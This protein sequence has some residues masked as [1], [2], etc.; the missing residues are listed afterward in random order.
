MSL[1]LFFTRYRSTITGA[2][3]ILA[4]S[5]LASRLLGLFRD[6]LLAGRFGTGKLLDAYQVSFLLPDL[7]YNLFIIG[8]L[9]A[10]LIPVF[11]EIY[12][13]NK[14]EAWDLISR[15]LNLLG[16]FIFGI[17]LVCFIFTPQIVHLLG[18]LAQ[19]SDTAYAEENL[20]LI[21]KLTRLML[22]SPLL[23]GL[24]SLTTGIL[25]SLKHFLPSALSPV[26]YNLGIILGILV[27]APFW[28]IYGVALGVV[29]GSL[30]HLAV[31]LPCFFSTGFKYSPVWR[32]KRE[33]KEVIKLAIPRTLGLI[34]AQTNL[35]INKIIAFTLGVGAISVYYFANNL[36]SFPV[37][38]FGVSLA[39][40]TFPNLAQATNGQKR[41]KFTE[42]LA[43]AFCHIIYLTVPMS[44]L[45]LL[46]RAQIVRIV[47]GTGEFD[48]PATIQTAKTL[49]FFAVSIFA[50]SVV[51]LLARAFYALKDTKTPVIIGVTSLILNV[52]LSIIFSR[53]LGVAGLALA[54]S[55]ASFLDMLLLLVV[56]RLKLDNLNDSRI[57]KCG[58]KIILASFLMGLATYGSLYLIAPLVNMRRFWGVFVQATGATL[59][60]VSIYIL[61]T[62]LLHCEEIEMIL[63]KIKNRLLHRG[64]ISP[65]K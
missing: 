39:I 43:T 33:V 14:Q 63:A 1:K 16:L 15:L 49:G 55:L 53:K 59:I 44:V 22:L 36:Q 19:I 8:A 29:V 35:W 46:L 3:I 48:W 7:I 60:G 13:R 51:L 24:S 20:D 17:L 21:V 23:L 28:N 64:L 52:I 4:F 56:L 45:F 57:I 32:I 5:S 34:A 40:A 2:S 41:K 61:L 9:S 50:Q 31:Q 54:Y 47:L 65:K 37:G 18:K 30:L 25:Q 26:F 11:L 10:G 42:T 62:L 12:T 6:R 38:L 58:L 27:F